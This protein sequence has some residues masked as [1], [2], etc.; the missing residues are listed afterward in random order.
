MRFCGLNRVDSLASAEGG[1]AHEVAGEH[2]IH[3]R[4]IYLKMGED[5][6]FDLLDPNETLRY[7]ISITL[8]PRDWALARGCCVTSTG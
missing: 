2:E 6:T 1:V 8:R 7:A 4:G 3:G 5:S